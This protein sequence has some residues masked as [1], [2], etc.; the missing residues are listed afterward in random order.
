VHIVIG[1]LAPKYLAIQR[2][3]AAAL[4]CAYPFDLFYRLV[5]PFNWFV[6]TSANSLLR[7]IGIKPPRPERPQR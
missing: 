3:V 2:S 4:L 5:Y 1:E 6:N 7:W